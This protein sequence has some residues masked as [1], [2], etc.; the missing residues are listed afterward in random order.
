MKYKLVY[1]KWEDSLVTSNKWVWDDEID[2]QSFDKQT[3]HLS[4]GFL[5]KETK[6]GLYL[7]QSR[8]NKSDDGSTSVAY[9]MYIPLSAIRK[10]K[11]LKI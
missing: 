5:I 4:V 1:I 3:I 8:K 6:R 9:P 7:S 11:I 10:R 2:Y